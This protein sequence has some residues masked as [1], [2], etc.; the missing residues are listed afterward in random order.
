MAEVR[1]TVPRRDHLRRVDEVA[2]GRGIDRAGGGE[3]DA[4]A[5]RHRHG[6]VDVAAARAAQV[7]P[8]VPAQVHVTPVSAAGNVSVTVAPLA[9]L[10]PSGLVTVM[11]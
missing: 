3:D 10:G 6:R 4:R 1:L 9:S 5:D 7:P 2:G 8:P 11:V